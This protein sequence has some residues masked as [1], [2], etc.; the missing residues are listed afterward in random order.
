[1]LASRQTVS[2][3]I[4]IMNCVIMMS[5]HVI[6]ETVSDKVGYVTMIMTVETTV[7]KTNVV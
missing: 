6:M 1:M 3:N 4:Q 2:V 5:S 7:M